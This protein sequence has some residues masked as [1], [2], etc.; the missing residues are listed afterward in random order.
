MADISQDIFF[1]LG[2]A[3]DFLRHVV[4]LPPQQAQLIIAD[5]RHLNIIVAVG[6][7][8]GTLRSWRIGR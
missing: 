2:G 8:A 4:E 5:Y 6:N 1:Q 3:F 7:L